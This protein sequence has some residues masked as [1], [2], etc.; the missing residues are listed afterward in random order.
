MRNKYLIKITYQDGSSE[1][2]IVNNY[3][4]TPHYFTYEYYNDGIC[5]III[6]LLTVKTIEVFED[7]LLKSLFYI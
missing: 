2:S 1:K 5:N 4:L 3:K 7:N 6:D